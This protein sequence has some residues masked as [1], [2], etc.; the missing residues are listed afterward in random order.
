MLTIVC[1]TG[2]LLKIMDKLSYSELQWR[3][4]NNTRVLTTL[5]KINFNSSFCNLEYLLSAFANDTCK[6]LKYMQI[7]HLK[8]NDSDGRQKCFNDIFS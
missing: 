6:N 2:Q 8:T 4:A 3:Y 1:V 5:E 7:R